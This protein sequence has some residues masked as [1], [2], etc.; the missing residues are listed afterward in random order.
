MHQGLSQLRSSLKPFSTSLQNSADSKVLYE[1]YSP[2]VFE[3]KL[4]NNKALNS[5]DKDMFDL[6]N[7]KLKE[8]DQG[9]GPRAV[10]ISGTGGKAF[11]AGGDIVS[12]YWANLKQKGLL[13]EIK[14]EF[15]AHEY[16]ADYALTTMKPL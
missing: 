9:E 10:M 13:P 15:F 7:G 11:C 14:A 5:L 4:N 12:L 6:I 1:K 3:F 16:L 2:D 8:W